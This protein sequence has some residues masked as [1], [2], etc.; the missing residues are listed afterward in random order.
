MYVLSQTG[1]RECHAC[2]KLPAPCTSE[3]SEKAIGLRFFI[4]VGLRSCCQTGPGQGGKF[5]HFFV[6]TK[7]WGVSKL[8][9]V[10]GLS[11][12]G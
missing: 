12:W 3:Q 9:L 4:H 2:E 11:P 10:R 6:W 8:G 7:F 5:T 1:K